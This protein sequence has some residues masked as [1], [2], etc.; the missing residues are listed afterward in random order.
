MQ[1]SGMEF[2]IIIVMAVLGASFIVGGI[3]GY[4]KSAGS[5]A[6]VISAAAIAAGIVMWAIIILVT[7]VFQQSSSTPSGLASPSPVQDYDSLVD[8]LRTAGATVEHSALPQVIVHDFFSVTGQVFKVNG[9]DVQ[10]F[11]YND[12]AAAKAEAALVSLDGSSI[13][14]SLPFWVAP[15]HFYKAGRII[16]LYVGEN[17]AVMDVLKSALGAQFAGR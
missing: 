9:E 10:L 16:V 12:N 1:V 4:R 7:P 3:V 6:K 14:T 5:R 8:N 17:I 13:G 11:E 2:P 15:P